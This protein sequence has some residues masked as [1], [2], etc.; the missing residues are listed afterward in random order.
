MSLNNISDI[1]IFIRVADAGSFSKAADLLNLSRSAVGKSIQRLE[2]RL[3][4]RLIHR[5][6][7]KLSLT[8]EGLLFYQA[9]QR[10]LHDVEDAENMMLKRHHSPKGRLRITMPVAFGRLHL[11]PILLDFLDV[12]PDIA[13]EVI[14]SDDYQDLIE[15]GIDLAIRFGQQK[16]SRLVQQRLAQH[17]LLVCA[18]PQYLA[19]FGQPHSP[20]DLL[21]HQ[22]LIYLHQGRPVAWRFQVNA[23][24]IRYAAQGRIRL[25]DVQALTDTALA[26]FGL[27]Q[28]GEF[29]VADSLAQG[30]LVEVLSAFRPAP[31]PICAVYPS[32]RHLS[33]KV[34]CLIDYI[35]QRWQQQPTWRESLK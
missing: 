3:S 13:L 5:T 34:S 19:Q 4:S 9:A 17:Q 1:V 28:V 16:D 35:R 30:Q 26:H 31:Q 6:T 20:E 11:M 15:D 12:Y 27:I 18:S 32:K 10:I 25:Y 8:D 33:P 14:F 23:E 22:Q 7:R 2:S 21:K 24:T 29:L